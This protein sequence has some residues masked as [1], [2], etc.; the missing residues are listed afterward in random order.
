LQDI[1]VIVV[2]L[3]PLKLNLQELYGKVTVW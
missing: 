3:F 1:D 2:F